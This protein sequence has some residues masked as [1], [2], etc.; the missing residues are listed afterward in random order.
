MLPGAKKTV[1][2]IL[3]CVLHVRWRTRAFGSCAM[4]PEINFKLEIDVGGDIL[5]CRSKSRR[6]GRQKVGG[7]RRGTLRAI[8]DKR[9]S[10]RRELFLFFAVRTPTEKSIRESPVFRGSPD[11]FLNTQRTHKPC[12]ES[13]NREHINSL[14]SRKPALLPPLA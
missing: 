1:I 12:S 9:L 6:A 4:N 7:I 2:L 3:S 14:E 5:R 10:P 13:A 8:L 11:F